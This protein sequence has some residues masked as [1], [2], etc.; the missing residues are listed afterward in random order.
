[1]STFDETY[2]RM[3]SATHARTQMELAKMLD[4]GQSSISDAKRRKSIP[5]EWFLRLHDRFG[6]SIDWLRGKDGPM[7]DHGS[8]FADE[9]EESPDALQ[10]NSTPKQ[11]M[12]VILPRIK[13]A[14]VSDNTSVMALVCEDAPL[15]PSPKGVMMR[16]Y[17]TNC[18]YED[19][20]DGAETKF[21]VRDYV[22]FPNFLGGKATHVFV[23]DSD[24]MAPTLRKGAHVG[25]GK[26]HLIS[27]EVFA[28]LMPHE[29]VVFRRIVQDA[30]SGMF[31]LSFD[32]P[33]LPP[34]L[35]S[36]ATLQSRLLG[37]V[38]WTVQAL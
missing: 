7:Y 9:P 10:Q 33:G 30:E 19:G 35:L 27:G 36:A 31:L 12:N 17:D 8:P 1:M 22:L 24:V 15:M 21:L 4:I 13:A 26:S 18:L 11:G 23:V 16:V 37:K 34:S 29:G 14:K 25:V 38:L 20:D 5:A 6:L 32:Q 28:V 3:K 2:E